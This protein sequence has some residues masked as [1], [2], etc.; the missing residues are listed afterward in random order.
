[1]KNK[2][3]GC[4][5]QMPRQSHVVDMI[6][7]WERRSEREIKNRGRLERKRKKKTRQAVFLDCVL[8]LG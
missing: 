6:Y 1:M 5:E 3:G 8:V 7:T 4:K 2:V